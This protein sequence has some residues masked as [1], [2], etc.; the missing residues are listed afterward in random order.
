MNTKKLIAAIQ[1]VKVPENLDLSTDELN[2][3]KAE[4]AEPFDMISL[5]FQCGFMRGRDDTAATIAMNMGT[6]R[7]RTTKIHSMVLA[8]AC[9]LDDIGGN[10]CDPVQLSPALHGAEEELRTLETDIETALFSK[11]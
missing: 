3:I 6:A 2:A 4:A 1:T 7:M 5:A 8:V 10:G 9:A 11:E